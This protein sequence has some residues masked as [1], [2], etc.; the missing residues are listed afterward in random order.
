MKA[1][2]LELQDGDCPT[3]VKF[4]DDALGIFHVP[5]YG[6]FEEPSVRE[7][8]SNG[9]TPEEWRNDAFDDRARQEMWGSPSSGFAGGNYERVDGLMLAMEIVRRFNAAC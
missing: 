6:H 9:I 4:E 2:L 5:V 8:V 7:R 1:E 3:L